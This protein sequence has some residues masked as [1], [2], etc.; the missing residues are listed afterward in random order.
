M[1]SFQLVV[2]DALKPQVQ[3]QVG[4]L[5]AVSRQIVGHFNHSPAAQKELADIQN[6]L[7]VPEKKLIQV[8][9]HACKN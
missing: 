9:K 5:L 4:D 3:R 6:S 7:N 1:F 2:N 8:N